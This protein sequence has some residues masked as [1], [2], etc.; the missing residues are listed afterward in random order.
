MYATGVAVSPQQGVFPAAAPQI[1]TFRLPPPTVYTLL[2]RPRCSNLEVCVES[3]LIKA[4]WA[5]H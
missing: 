1:K 5:S 4:Q 3:K 2:G